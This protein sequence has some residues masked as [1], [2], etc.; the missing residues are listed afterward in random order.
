MLGGKGKYN[1]GLFLFFFM[2]KTTHT[3]TY[4]HTHIVANKIHAVIKQN[5]VVIE[6]MM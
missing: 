3:H 4:T 2:A 1:G 5:D 6:K